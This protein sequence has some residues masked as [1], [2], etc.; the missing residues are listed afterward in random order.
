[1]SVP[2]LEQIQE[3]WKSG[4]ILVD[5]GQLDLCQNIASCWF[6]QID[7]VTYLIQSLD[8]LERII[9]QHFCAGNQYLDL[10]PEFQVS[11]ICPS[12]H[13]T[14]VKLTPPR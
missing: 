4:W 5:Q 10:C 6:E 13:D 2:L 7:R 12:V 8:V 3:D 9:E 1:M 11:K 14:Y